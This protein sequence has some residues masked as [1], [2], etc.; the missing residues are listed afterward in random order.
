MH[1]LKMGSQL[2]DFPSQVPLSSQ[3]VEGQQRA[4]LQF[5]LQFLTHHSLS[6]FL[7][8][9]FAGNMEEVYPLHVIHKSLLARLCVCCSTEGKQLEGK[10][11]IFH[12]YLQF[13]VVFKNKLC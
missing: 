10:H 8:P 11:Y 12:L 7:P 13:V 2:W 9:V 5:S 1:S 4:L 6:L 3:G